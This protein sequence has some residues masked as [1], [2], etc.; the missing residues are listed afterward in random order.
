M[1]TQKNTDMANPR[2]SLYAV[3]MLKGLGELAKRLFTAVLEQ[4]NMAE[5]R[6][7][8]DSGAEGCVAYFM[9][10][11]IEKAK[12]NMPFGLKRGFMWPLISIGSC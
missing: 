12:H 6:L 9:C 11:S 4:I 3:K 2:R 5:K 1:I 8:Q 7:W 10:Y